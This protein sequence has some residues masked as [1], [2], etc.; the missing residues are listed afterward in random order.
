MADAAQ[1]TSSDARSILQEYQDLPMIKRMSYPNYVSPGTE[2]HPDHPRSSHLM[3]TIGIDGKHYAYPALVEK[4]GRLVR[5]DPRVTVLQDRNAIP[6]SNL[7]EAERFARGSW[8]Q[9]RNLTTGNLMPDPNVDTT[10]SNQAQNAPVQD[11][12][13]KAIDAAWE[14]VESNWQQLD[15]QWNAGELTDDE[16]DK[17][18]DRVNQGEKFAIKAS[19]KRDQELLDQEQDDPQLFIN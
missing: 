7:E 12:R 1:G 3:G 17:Y 10:N 2:L 9:A 13:D 6:F 8:K 14:Y 4:D 18:Y 19:L 11:P 15:D 5:Q 16:W